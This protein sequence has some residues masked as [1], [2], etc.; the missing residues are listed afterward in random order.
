M[1]RPFP[2]DMSKMPLPLCPAHPNT[3]SFALWYPSPS[4]GYGGG[5]H[6]V[7]GRSVGQRGIGLSHAL[8]VGQGRG[9]GRWQREGI[10]AHI[11]EHPSLPHSH[12]CTL[13]GNYPHSSLWSARRLQ[14]APNSFRQG[15]QH[16]QGPPSLSPSPQTC[17]SFARLNDVDQATILTFVR[18]RFDGAGNATSRRHL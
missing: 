14:G 17:I 4:T 9:D 3:S 11:G 10:Q 13:A 16:S 15:P 6:G 18:L 8:V 1:C 5:G 2:A 7:V 12:T